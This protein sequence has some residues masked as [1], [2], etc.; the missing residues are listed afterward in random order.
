LERAAS[1]IRGKLDAMVSS[2][3]ADSGLPKADS[4]YLRLKG[5][6]DSDVE[7]INKVAWAHDLEGIFHLDGSSKSMQAEYLKQ[8]AIPSDT[9]AREIV[10]SVYG[11]LARRGVK[12]LDGEGGPMFDI[13][14]DTIFKSVGRFLS[15]A[16][17]EYLELMRR[18]QAEPGSDDGY[19]KI[20]WAEFADRI[21]MTDHIATAYPENPFAM[22]MMADRNHSLRNYLSGAEGPE[23][24][25]PVLPAQ[26]KANIEYFLAKYGSTPAAALV[27][28]YRRAVEVQGYRDGRTLD[29]F[30]AK[31]P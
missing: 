20:S 9:V 18:Q 2:L 11:F 8:R 28:G 24:P 30:F 16:G 6:L 17:R 19:L 27:R 10:D 3:R 15:P 5:T 13:A 22:G 23:F 31:L 29:E 4:E 1:P 14:D 26:A 7:A 21:A 25:S 12:T